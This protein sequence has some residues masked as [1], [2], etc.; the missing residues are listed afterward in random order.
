MNVG[1]YDKQISATADR[2][3]R[4]AA[5]RPPCMCAVHNVDAQ[6]DKLA[7]DDGRRAVANS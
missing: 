1:R 4:R 7:T 5:L 6:C 3:A 2:P